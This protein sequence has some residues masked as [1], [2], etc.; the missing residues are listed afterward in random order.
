MKEYDEKSFLRRLTHKNPPV[1]IQIE[2]QWDAINKVEKA[3]KA[4][5]QLGTDIVDRKI[6]IEDINLKIDNLEIGLEL[7]ESK[8]EFV[9]NNLKKS[10][11]SSKNKRRQNLKKCFGLH[12]E[13]KNDQEHLDQFNYKTIKLAWFVLEEYCRWFNRVH[14]NEIKQH[15]K[16]IA[17]QKKREKRKAEKPNTKQS[18]LKAERS[19]IIQKLLQS[20]P[21]LN[22]TQIANETEIPRSS[23]SR[24]MKKIRPKNG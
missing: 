6:A 19:D 15:Q 3:I 2:N 18:K 21:N 14:E 12:N 23:V 22:S 4:K 1:K 7:A 10:I 9:S 16:E 5:K 13:I 24:L 11:T 17:N 8:L 20:N